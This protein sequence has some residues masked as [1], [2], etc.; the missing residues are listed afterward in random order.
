MFNAT[1]NRSHFGRGLFRRRATLILS[2]ALLR[3]ARRKE[4]ADETSFTSAAFLFI[5]ALP[6]K[7][8]RLRTGRA[9]EQARRWRSM[10]PPRQ[11]S[12]RRRDS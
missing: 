1:E 9:D 6:R 7:M 3:V 11:K 8:R 5:D 4:G 2:S 12:R 10:R